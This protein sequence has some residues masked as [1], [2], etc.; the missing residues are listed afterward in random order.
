MNRSVLADL[1]VFSILVVAMQGLGAA[2]TVSC[3]DKSISAGAVRTRDDIKAFVICAKELIEEVGEDSAYDAF[4]NDPRWTSGPIYLFITELIPDGTKARSLVHTGRPARETTDPALLGDRSDDFGSDIIVEAYRIITT[5]GG[6]WWYYGFANYETGLVSPKASY[7]LPIEWR[8]IPAFVGSGIYQR[9]LPGTC[10][11]DEVNASV[12]AADP[13]EDRLQE[14]V[15]CAALEMESM[16]Y[17]ASI[18]LSSD[19]RW[20]QDSIYVFGVD[21]NG[22]TLFSGDPYRW[23]GWALGGQD[24]ELASFMNER[25]DVRLADTFGESFF[26]YETRNSATGMQ[27]QKVVF[28]KRVVTYGLPILIGSGYFVDE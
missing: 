24:S 16:G 14:F 21:G 26:Y 7:I 12:L 25:D 23:G 2:E 3:T 20:R 4:H 1:A 13:S 9:D 6:G 27:Q 11:S 10:R 19:P 28:V 8:G 5:R 17:F 18:G 15:R 22:N